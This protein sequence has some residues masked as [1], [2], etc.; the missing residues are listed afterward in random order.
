M[1]KHFC[2]YQYVG[3]NKAIEF[4][5]GIHKEWS[6]FELIFKLTRHCDHAGLNFNIEIFGM[7]LSF[8]FYDSRH[9]NYDK[10]RYYIPGEEE[11][12]E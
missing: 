7:W 4:E 12:V 10:N 6:W 1:D 11:E 9:W 8:N 5:G 2:F 3:K